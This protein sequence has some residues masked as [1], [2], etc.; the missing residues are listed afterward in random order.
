MRTPASAAVFEGYAK[1]SARFRRVRGK[2]TERNFPSAAW[3][4]WV[5]SRR[6]RVDQEIIVGDS[7]GRGWRR[8]RSSW[9][10]PG[11]PWAWRLQKSGA[12]T[13][14]QCIRGGLDTTSHGN[15]ASLTLTLDDTCPRPPVNALE[16]QSQWYRSL[17]QSRRA[18]PARC[19]IT[20]PSGPT[21]PHVLYLTRLDGNRHVR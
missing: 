8:R 18:R 11:L 16:H 4:W 19:A 3:P 12:S 21:N 2:F 1:A 9:I 20:M 13:H 14:P 5:S 17:L 6:L 10:A 15:H 7:Q